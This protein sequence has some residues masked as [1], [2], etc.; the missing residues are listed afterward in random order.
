MPMQEL[1]EYVAAHTSRTACRCGKCFTS[2]PDKLPGQESEWAVGA[3]HHTA[4]MVF[5][6]VSTVD[7]PS[8]DVLRRLVGEN[9]DNGEFGTRL[10]MLDNLEHSYIEVGHWI[11]DQGIAM[12]LMGL[13]WLL[14]LWQV[15]TPKLIGA[16]QDL[17]IPMAEAGYLSLIPHPPGKEIRYTPIGQ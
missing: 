8:P 17:A 6:E 4:D 1:R 10:D 14:G 12:Q 13:G 2:G 7:N 15:M 16:P 11:G 9:I 5:F 3:F